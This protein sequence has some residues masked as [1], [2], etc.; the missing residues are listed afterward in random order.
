MLES[1]STSEQKDGDLLLLSA[2]QLL[3]CVKWVEFNQVFVKHFE[4]ETHFVCSVTV[5][6]SWFYLSVPILQMYYMNIFL[7][8]A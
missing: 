4:D 5:D 6:L 1:K 2:E 3:S 8:R 7:L